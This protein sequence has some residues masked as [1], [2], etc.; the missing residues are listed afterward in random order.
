MYVMALP[1]LYVHRSE[2]WNG[3]FEKKKIPCALGKT[4]NGDA[5]RLGWPKPVDKFLV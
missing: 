2:N 5:E 4:S 3:C 1:A